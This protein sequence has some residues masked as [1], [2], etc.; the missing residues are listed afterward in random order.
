MSAPLVAYDALTTV[1][2]AYANLQLTTSRVLVWHLADKPDK[3]YYWE[4][5]TKRFKPCNSR[6]LAIEPRFWCYK[7]IV[8][9]FGNTKKQNAS[10]RMVSKDMGPRTEE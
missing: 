3:K 9:I 5:A 10:K 8:E 7:H 1:E 6:G 4:E 2:S